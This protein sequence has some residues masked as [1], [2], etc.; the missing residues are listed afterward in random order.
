MARCRLPIR[1]TPRSVPRRGWQTMA[2]CALV[3]ALTGCTQDDVASRFRAVKDAPVMLNLARERDAGSSEPLRA[4]PAVAA[5]ELTPLVSLGR[6]LFHD[7]RLSGDDTVACA[8]CHDIGQGGDDGA[9]VSS[10]IKGKLGPINAPTVLNAA[11]N[12]RQFW[13]GR[14]KDLDE[15]ARGPVTNP[16]E[17]GADWGKV[18]AKLQADTEYPAQFAAA[19]GDTLIDQDRIAAAIAGFEATLVTQAPFD[20][21]LL[22]DETAISA[23]AQQG[24]RLFKD[25]GCVGCHQGINVGGNLYQKFGAIN[26][27]FEIASDADHGLMNRTQNADDKGVFKVPGLRNVALT[28]PYFHLG[29]VNELELAV[30]IMA[31][32]QL[33]R[34]LDDADIRLIVAFLESLSGELPQYV[35]AAAALEQLQ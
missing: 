35:A 28:A 12:F 24:Y 6:R 27:A 26:S 5:V 11:F 25:Y 16:L 3:L 23:E 30:R 32:T 34:T 8:S 1:R 33:G 31:N 18:V 15:Q 7:P 20:R 21:W 29:N 13:D 14:A 4:L 10:G 19:F 2:G 9:Q 22:G 17:M